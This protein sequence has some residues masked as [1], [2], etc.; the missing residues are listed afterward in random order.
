MVFTGPSTLFLPPVELSVLETGAHGDDDAVD[1]ITKLQ[2]SQ[3]FQLSYV[4]RR[5][6]YMTFGG[7]RVLL[8]GDSFVETGKNPTHDGEVGRVSPAATLKEWNVAGEVWVS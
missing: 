4:A 2:A 1:K 3:H 6:G 5:R 7:L 8:V